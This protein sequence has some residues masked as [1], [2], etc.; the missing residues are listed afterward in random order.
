M[1]VNIYVTVLWRMVS[2]NM[3]SV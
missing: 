1:A 2:C 3:L